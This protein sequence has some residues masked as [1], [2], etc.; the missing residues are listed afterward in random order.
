MHRTPCHVR[1]IECIGFRRD[2]GLWEIEGRLTDTKGH[3]H[4]TREKIVPKGAAVHD[5]VIK[6]TVNESLEVI[7]VIAGIEASPYRVCPSVAARYKALKGVQ[8]MGADF[9]K[10]VRQLFRGPQGCTHV[11]D[12]LMTTA[13]TAFQ[14]IVGWRYNR[15]A[16][17]SG[18]ANLEPYTNLMVGACYGLSSGGEPVRNYFGAVPLQVER[19]NVN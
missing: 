15:E 16:N 9:S 10:K 14:T 8:L 7:E 18:D 19:K 11:S 13:T 17:R 6:L 3:D 2:D 4:D 5:M 1:K 12:L